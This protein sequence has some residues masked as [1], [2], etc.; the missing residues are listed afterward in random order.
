MSERGLQNKADYNSSNWE[1]GDFPILCSSCIGQSSFVRLVL[2]V[3]IH[4]FISNLCKYN[5]TV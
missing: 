4:I 5:E 2:L 3:L 1:S